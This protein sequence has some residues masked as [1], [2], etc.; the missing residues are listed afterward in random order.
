MILY[1][2]YEIYEIVSVIF[3]YSWKDTADGKKHTLTSGW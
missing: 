3:F 1:L 2:K